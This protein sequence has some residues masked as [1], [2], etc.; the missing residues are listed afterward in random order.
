MERRVCISTTAKMPR[1]NII[2][3]GRNIMYNI[4][5]AEESRKDICSKVLV[6]FKMRARK[7]ACDTAQAITR[8]LQKVVMFGRSRGKSAHTGIRLK[9]NQLQINQI[10]RRHHI[11]HRILQH[12]HHWILHRHHTRHQIL[13]RCRYRMLR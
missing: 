3:Q 2:H 1:K 6:K 4:L 5:V 7:C 13:R 8:G 12:T 11:H 10:L 9:S